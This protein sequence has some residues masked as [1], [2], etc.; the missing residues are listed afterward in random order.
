MAA[1]PLPGYLIRRS[2]TRPPAELVSQFGQFATANLSDVMGKENTFDY[3]I[4]PIHPSARLLG[5]ALTVKIRPG[6]N[7]ISMKAIELAQPGDILVIS[8]GFDH[9]YSVWGGIMSLMARRKG[10]SGVL[11]DGLVRDAAQIQAAGLVVFAAGLT[12]V[13]PSK[14]GRGQINLPVSCGGIVVHPGDIVVGDADCAVIV[15]REQAQS[16]LERAHQRIALEASWMARIE[17]GEFPLISP[18]EE[19][20]GRGCQFV[21][22]EEH[23]ATP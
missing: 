8:G 1:T 19:M 22:D 20:I 18:D 15:P 14:D 2:F 9:N 7:L 16:V 11:T 13:G 23:A 6:D 21:W 3:R 12:P 10:I 5:V 4:K 17:K